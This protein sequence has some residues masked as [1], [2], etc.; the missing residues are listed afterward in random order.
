MRAKT[1]MPPILAA[2]KAK[3]PR[4]AKAGAILGAQA[5]AQPE[6]RAQPK[7]EKEQKHKAQQGFTHSEQ[8]GPKRGIGQKITGKPPIKPK[9]GK[10]IRKRQARDAEEKLHPVHAQ[11]QLVSGHE[12]KRVK[13][14]P[15]GP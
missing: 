7:T 5:L 1:R 13:Y 12:M 15:N 8:N 3:A 6:P 4:N 2:R 11:M 9:D 10:N 14:A